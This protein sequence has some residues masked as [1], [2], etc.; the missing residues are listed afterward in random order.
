MSNPVCLRSGFGSVCFLPCSLFLFLLWWA[1]E[2]R[3]TGLMEGEGLMFEIACWDKMM[4]KRGKSGIPAT[5]VPL[6]T[7]YVHT[8]LCYGNSHGAPL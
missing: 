3:L 2:W 1:V 8:N 7:D 4:K 6:T 5:A